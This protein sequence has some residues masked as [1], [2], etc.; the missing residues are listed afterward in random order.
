MGM[1][2]KWPDV[3]LDAIQIFQSPTGEGLYAVHWGHPQFGVNGAVWTVEL[4]RNRA[5]N[6]GPASKTAGSFS[7]WGMQV[8]PAFRWRL[9][10]TD[11]RFQG[12]S[13]GWW[14]RS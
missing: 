2:T 8:L 10:R 13:R 12:I 3:K 7:G 9:S 4:E 5:R 1:D 11:V 6:I 14:S